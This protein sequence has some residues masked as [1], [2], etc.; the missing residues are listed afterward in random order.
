MGMGGRGKLHGEQGWR[1]EVEMTALRT[2]IA[3][4]RTVR[5]KQYS[6]Q[7]TQ[8]LNSLYLIAK[9]GGT[10]RHSSTEYLGVLSAGIN[11]YYTSFQQL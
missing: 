11:P 5:K 8:S 4:V 6:Y 10:I 2:V 3:D 9:P 7:V 1:G